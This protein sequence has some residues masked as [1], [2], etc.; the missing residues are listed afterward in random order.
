MSMDSTQ[1]CVLAKSG[2]PKQRKLANK[3]APLRKDGHLLLIT[4]VHSCHLLLPP[5]DHGLMIWMV[6]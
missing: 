6:F 4:F 5:P 2:T 3:I 1:L